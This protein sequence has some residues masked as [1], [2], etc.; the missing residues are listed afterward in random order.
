MTALIEDYKTTCWGCGLHLLVSPYAPS[1]K[2]FWCGAITNQNAVEVEN[3]NFKWRRL[4]DRGFVGVL[5]VI[6]LIVIC[7]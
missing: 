6:M 5:V 2:C 4:R 3:K 1:F 7:K